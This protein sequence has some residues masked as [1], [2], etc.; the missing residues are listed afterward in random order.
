MRQ[1]AQKKERTREIKKERKKERKKEGRKEERMWG[2]TEGVGRNEVGGRKKGREG[3]EGEK[4]EMEGGRRKN[5]E[6]GIRRTYNDVIN[7]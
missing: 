7:K 1:E 6:P 5:A 4:G 2:R 3:E